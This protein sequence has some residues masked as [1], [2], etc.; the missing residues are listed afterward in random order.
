MEEKLQKIAEEEIKKITEAYN[1]TIVN[2]D[3]SES[4]RKQGY[5]DGL[6]ECLEYK[7]QNRDLAKGKEFARWNLNGSL[8]QKQWGKAAYWEAY[9][10]GFEVMSYIFDASSV[11]GD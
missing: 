5:L 3:Y 7:I 4:N 2:K 9:I 8:D 11:S 1:R 10:N 6:Q